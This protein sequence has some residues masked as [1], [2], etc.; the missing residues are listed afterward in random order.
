MALMYLKYTHICSKVTPNI[1]PID[2]Y[3][4]IDTTMSAIVSLYSV[5]T[6]NKN[7]YAIVIIIHI[8]N[9]VIVTR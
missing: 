8:R 7:V 1:A 2:R 3:T 9:A 4:R 6:L 5:N